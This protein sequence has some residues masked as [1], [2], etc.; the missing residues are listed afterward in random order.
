[1]N[2]F[3]KPHNNLGLSATLSGTGLGFRKE[4]VEKDGFNTK[5][6]TED[7]EFATQQSIKG[8]KIDYAENAFS[9]ISTLFLLTCLPI[10]V[11]ISLYRSLSVP[12]G[13]GS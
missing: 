2:L 11:T 13:F 7:I 8:I 9:P 1:M 10:N 6:M 12:Q 3:C 4:L 5:T